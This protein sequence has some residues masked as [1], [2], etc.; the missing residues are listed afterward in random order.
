MKFL[1]I[2]ILSLF[3]GVVLFASC[4]G[5]PGEPAT[6]VASDSVNASHR[7]IA[8]RDS[9]IYGEAGD[10]GMST[11]SLISDA[12]DSLLLTRTDEQGRDGQIFGD[13]QPGD[14]YAIIISADRQS[15]VSAINLTQLVRFTKDYKIVNGRLILSPESKPDEVTI[16]SLDDDSLVVRGSRGVE[17]LLP[18]ME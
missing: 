13:A 12:G 1:N 2:C 9:T 15:L 11:F 14:R 8:E 10:F 6:I 17:R 3:V 18:L 4:K 5:K 7:V 16:V